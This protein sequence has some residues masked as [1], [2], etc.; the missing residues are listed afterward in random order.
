MVKLNDGVLGDRA[1]RPGWGGQSPS[2]RRTTAQTNCD[3]KCVA[4]L[5]KHEARRIAVNITKLPELLT[6]WGLQ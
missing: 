2:P 4:L 1:I 6:T 3:T 5:T